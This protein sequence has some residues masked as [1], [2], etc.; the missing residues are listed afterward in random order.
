MGALLLNFGFCSTGKAERVIIWPD[1]GELDTL[2]NLYG[3]LA[4]MTYSDLTVFYKATAT[5]SSR[6]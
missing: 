4:H 6:K 3:G 2:S 5:S 1:I